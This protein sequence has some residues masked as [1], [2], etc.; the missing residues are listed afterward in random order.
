MDIEPRSAE[1]SRTHTARMGCA[2]ALVVVV[3]VASVAFNAGAA[4]PGGPPQKAPCSALAPA[5]ASSSGA[6]TLSASTATVGCIEL[7]VRGAL[8]SSVTLTEL[9]SG[10]PT[11]APVGELDTS[12]G[13]ASLATGLMWLCDRPTREF[14]VAETLP[15]GTTQSASTSASTPSC[16]TRL[17]ARVLPMRL[18]RGYPATV[19]VVDRWALGGLRVHVCSP[20]GKR[21]SC[22]AATLKPG[23]GETILRT[24][25]KS[26]GSSALEVS[27]QYQKVRLPLHVL[28]SR[29]L[30][31]A[32]G[33]SEM[34]VLDDDLGADLSG[35]G[36]AAVSSDARQSTAISSPFF[37][38]WPGHAFGQVAEHHPDIVAMFLGGNEGFRLGHAECCGAD[39]SREYAGRVAAMMRVYRQGGAAA[40]YWFLIP[41]PSREPFIKVVSAVNRGIVS[42]AARFREG[43]HFFDLRPTFSPGGR[44]IDSLTRDGQ[45][46]TVHE[47][48]GFH[49]SESADR[50]VARMFIARLRRDGLLP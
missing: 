15:D 24:R 13:T 33:D 20:T 43:V 45:T 2:L 17:A 35:S 16:T 42:A 27:D 21:R 32:T 6:L 22:L 31:L 25:L 34:Q 46:I 18:H 14:Q 50:I 41:T 30:L 44:Y 11:G 5:Q 7:T 29:P 9:I 4:T 1:N 48:D 39:W 49:L 12:G 40:V 36:G 23:R 3:L 38:N 10:V 19:A 37:F 8:A 47:S 28:S 26:A